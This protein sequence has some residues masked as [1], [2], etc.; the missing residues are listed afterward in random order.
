MEKLM[1]PVRQRGLKVIEDCAHAFP[2]QRG[3]VQA[4]RW[5]DV[6]VFSFYAT[7]T[8][9]SGEGGMVIT[10]DEELA[11]RISRLRLHGIDRRVWDRF[12]SR[13]SADWEYDVT[14]LGYKYNLTDLAAAIG[15]IQLERGEE[16]LSARRKIAG[17]YL[18]EFKDIPGSSFLPRWR[19]IRGTSS[20][21]NS[22]RV[23]F[24]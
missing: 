19:G 11:R 3:G 13:K 24:P 18:E 9:T 22:K 6:G 12:Q 14:A 4:G 8:I 16:F 15:R 7:K 5:G 2:A 20:S 1:P 23:F 10:E 21:S 17:V